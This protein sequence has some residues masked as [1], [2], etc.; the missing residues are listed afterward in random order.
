[1]S[2]DTFLPS[3]TLTDAEEIELTK[4]LNHPLIQKYLRI[5]AT[6]ET[7]DLLSMSILDMSGQDI[8]SRHLLVTGK[9]EV[10]TTLLSIQE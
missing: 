1:M 9:L 10:L 3:V 6:E 2:L 5:L 8:A 4:Q 7:K